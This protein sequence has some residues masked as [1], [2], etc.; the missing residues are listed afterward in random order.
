M[1]ISFKPWANF[2]HWGTS[3]YLELTWG[4]RLGFTAWLCFIML[5]SPR[6]KNC[7]STISVTKTVHP[8][9]SWLAIIN[10]EMEYTA[11]LSR[12]IYVLRAKEHKHLNYVTDCRTGAVGC[13]SYNSELKHSNT[14]PSKERKHHSMS[15]AWKSQNRDQATTTRPQD[16]LEN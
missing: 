10:M 11:L 2:H 13:Q 12:T 7:W 1:V 5:P 15:T 6:L 4:G 9:N 16:Y 14:E 8:P 3:W